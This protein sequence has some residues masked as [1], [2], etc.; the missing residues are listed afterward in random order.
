MP[1]K[2]A[3]QKITTKKKTV[4]AARVRGTVTK[5]TTASKAT[6]IIKKKIMTNPAEAIPRRNYH[7]GIQLAIAGSAVI[8][9]VLLS[10][11]ERN[12][13]ATKPGDAAAP[14]VTIGL[15]HEAPLSLTVLFAKKEKSGYVSLVNLSGE[16]IHINVP[17]HWK[18]SEVTGT[19][20]ANVVQEIP[21]F[22][23]TRYSL[24]A[25]A[26]V[27]MLLPESPTSVF[28]DSTSDAITTVDLKTVDLTTSDTDRRVLLLQK[29]LL[30]PL[31][32][33]AE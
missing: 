10:A 2:P 13:F 7:L 25:G 18:R 22:G 8:V 3:S 9:L 21:V 26:G 16:N 32:T 33:K 31:W 11:L 27:K 14:P 4:S 29:Q 30:V 19:D 24:P 5:K 1:S 6:K 17:S 20:I 12:T 15:E 28:F 23:F